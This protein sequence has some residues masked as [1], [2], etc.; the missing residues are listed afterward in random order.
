MDLTDEEYEKLKELFIL[1]CDNLENKIDEI[2]DKITHYGYENLDDSDKANLMNYSKDDEDIHKIV[3]DM[4]NLNKDF[5]KLN[6]Q[7]QI[8]TK[9]DEK[10]LKKVKKD[11]IEMHDKMSEYE[12]KLIHLYKIE[13]PNDFLNYQKKNNLTF[14]DY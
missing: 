11:W 9:G 6:Q 14:D 2:L 7:L 12:N 4:S 10:Q 13:D 8:I 1:K 5:L 3:L